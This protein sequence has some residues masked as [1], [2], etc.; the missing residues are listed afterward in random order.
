MKI[1][2]VLLLFSNCLFAQKDTI[3]NKCPLGQTYITGLHSSGMIVESGCW[4]DSLAK[5]VIHDFFKELCEGECGMD[6]YGE[7]LL[8]SHTGHFDDSCGCEFTD[9]YMKAVTVM[10]K[11]KK[12]KKWV[13]ISHEEY[14]QLCKCE[15]LSDSTGK[16]I[17]VWKQ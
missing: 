14:S 5:K 2:I 15:Y 11:K 3:K 1:V 7:K 13:N 9:V 17:P 10:N 6:S 12:V 16:P 4:P 8:Q